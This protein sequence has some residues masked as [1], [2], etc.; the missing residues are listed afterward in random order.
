MKV[1]SSFVVRPDPIEVREKSSIR[2]RVALVLAVVSIAMIGTGLGTHKVMAEPPVRG[3]SN[4]IGTSGR[5]GTASPGTALSNEVVTVSWSGF[6]TTLQNGLYGV[7]IV[8]CKGTPATLADCYTAEPYPGISNGTRVLSSTGSDGTGSARI[9]IRP[10]AY[11]PLLNCSEINAC[12]V[13]A[14]END[15]Q[16]IPVGGLPTNRV[17]VPIT[18]ALSQADCPSITDFDVRADGS[19]TSAE[20]FYEWAAKLCTGDNPVVVDYTENSSTSG[21]ENFL[22]GLTD[23]GVTALPATA[24]ELEAH[25]DHRDFNYVPLVASATVIAYNFT[26]PFTRQPLDNLVLSPRL[27]A[28]II[29]NTSLE[30]FFQDRELRQLNPGV[31]F[32]TSVLARPLLRAERN[33]DTRIVTSW[34]SS[35]ATAREFLADDDRFRISVNPAYIGYTYPQDIFETVSQDSLYLPRQGQRSVSL[36]LFYGVTPTGTERET[37]SSTGIIG[38]VDL[39]TAKRFGLKVAKIVQSDGTSVAPTDESI[40]AGIADMDTTPEGLLVADSTPED[41]LA[42]PLVKIDYAMVPT[43]FATQAKVDKVLRLLQF[44]LTEGQTALPSGYVALPESIKSTALSVVASISA[45][46]TTTTTTTTSTTTT[47]TTTTVVKEKYYPPATTAAPETTTTTTST[48]TSTSTSTTTLAPITVPG[49]AAELPGSGSSKS[50]VL[51][52]GLIGLSSAALM[53][54]VKPRKK[55]A[56]S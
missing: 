1:S 15:G 13:M 9:E 29:T 47:T 19:A 25:P 45:P 7:L 44:G 37:T 34:F 39:P 31:R 51:Y 10:S 53:G 24:E 28:R 26:D 20:L 56:N 32:P 4:G 49:I 40:L 3:D 33:A 38:V 55:I 2:Q 30:N 17:I 35:N 43:K 23:F 54:T 27:V 36:K 16:T 21:R 18:F 12:S 46:T 48:S 5:A 8:Q 52:A 41:V 22:A 11:L 6:N 42:Y 50:G 14:Y